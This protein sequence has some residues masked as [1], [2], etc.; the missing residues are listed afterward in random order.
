[1]T[2]EQNH[3]RDQALL[4]LRYWRQGGTNFTSL[5]FSLI[6]KSD[7]DNLERIALGFPFEVLVWQEWQASKDEIEYFKSNGMP[8]EGDF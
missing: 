2:P 8:F 3:A 4:R 5:L 6:S 1:M 7:P